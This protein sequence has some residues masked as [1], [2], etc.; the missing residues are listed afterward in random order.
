M[1]YK[2]EAMIFRQPSGLSLESS[3]S[4]RCE[5]KS[6]HYQIGKR[7]LYIETDRLRL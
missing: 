3:D 5:L 6:R 1:P 4:R 7:C 2:P